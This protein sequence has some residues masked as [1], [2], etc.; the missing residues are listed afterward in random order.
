[1]RKGKGSNKFK[2]PIQLQADSLLPDTDFP[3]TFTIP[4]PK[5]KLSSEVTEISTTKK[6]KKKCQSNRLM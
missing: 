6:K 1:M 5:P 2:F 4:E 3:D